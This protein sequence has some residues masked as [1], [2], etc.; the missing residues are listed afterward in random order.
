MKTV[1]KITLSLLITAVLLAGSLLGGVLLGDPLIAAAQEQVPLI[2]VSGNGTVR[3]S[4]DEARVSL[5]ILTMA[6]TAKEAQQTNN[7]LANK[8]IAAL[9]NAGTPREKIET[10]DYS[11][12]PEYKYPKP[13]ENKPPS[14]IGYRACNN[15]VITLEDIDQVGMIIDTAVGAG[16]NQV[17]DIQFLKRETGPAQQEALK[18]A[19][20][21]ARLKAEAIAQS[22]DVHLAGLYSVQESGSTVQPLVY[23]S[24]EKVLLD[25]ASTPVQPGELEVN[26]NVT[27]VFRIK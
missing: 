5:G 11:I 22:M 24:Q 27:V 7:T 1:R 8:V 23:R 17:Q 2:T 12:W 15:V 21:D 9:V 16:A 3:V 14:V 4:P 10:R 13:E 26:A 6:S 18:K 20:Q 25:G 19:C